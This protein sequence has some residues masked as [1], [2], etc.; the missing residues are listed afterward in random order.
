MPTEAQNPTLEARYLRDKKVEQIYG[1]S[2]RQLRRW[3]ECGIG[4]EFRRLSYKTL[5]YEVRSL[6]DWIASH[7]G[8]GDGAPH[9]TL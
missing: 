4:P 9:P 3:R 8:L 5:V 2:R 7:P 6:E 1:L